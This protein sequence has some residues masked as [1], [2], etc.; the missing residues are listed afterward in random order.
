MEEVLFRE[1][2]DESDEGVFG[3]VSCEVSDGFIVVSVPSDVGAVHDEGCGVECFV[4]AASDE[5]RDVVEL[6]VGV[7]GE[8]VKGEDNEGVSVLVVEEGGVVGD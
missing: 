8:F 5:G 1:E 2:V 6:V 4:G 3:D 7:F